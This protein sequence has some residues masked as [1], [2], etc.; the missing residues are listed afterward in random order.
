MFEPIIIFPEITQFF[1]TKQLFVYYGAPDLSIVASYHCLD[2][3]RNMQF[4][5]KTSN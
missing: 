4:E 2:D 5:S 3:E 1:F